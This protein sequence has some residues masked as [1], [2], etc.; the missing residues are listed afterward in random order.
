MVTS[1]TTTRLTMDMMEERLK[2]QL[3]I[4]SAEIEEMGYS[5]SSNG[6][7]VEIINSERCQEDLTINDWN[8][9]LT[10]QT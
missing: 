3:E 6:V 1:G 7:K 2:D 9:F 5:S 8:R 4:T 10:P